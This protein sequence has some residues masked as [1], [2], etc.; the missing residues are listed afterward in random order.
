MELCKA[1]CPKN[2]DF[3]RGSSR[4]ICGA[5]LSQFII[6]VQCFNKGRIQ[7]LMK[8]LKRIIINNNRGAPCMFM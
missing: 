8:P 2:E 4:I 3:D 1:W 7:K 6:M 5:Q